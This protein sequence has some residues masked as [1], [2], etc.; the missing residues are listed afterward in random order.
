[1][2]DKRKSNRQAATTTATSH[3][4]SENLLGITLDSQPSSLFVCSVGFASFMSLLDGLRALEQKK[5]TEAIIKE[6]K[7]E[8]DRNDWIGE[9]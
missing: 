1:V 5:N 8:R 7:S 2:H 3:L 6:R 4:M 9:S